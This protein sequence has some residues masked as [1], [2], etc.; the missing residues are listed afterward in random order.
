[1]RTLK[2]QV[3]ITVD[4][5][6]AG[7]NGEMDMMAGH[8]DEALIQY[9]RELTDPIDCVVL[10]RKLAEG[11]I[12]H[13]ANVAKN[14]DHPE[15]YAGVKFTETPKVVFTKTLQKSSW[16]NTVLAKGDIVDEINKLKKQQGSDIIAYGGA[17]FVSSLIRHG[18]IDDMHLFIS[19]VAIG[20]G[21]A[22]FNGLDHYQKYDLVKASSFDCGIQ[23]LHYR[24]K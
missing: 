8:W 11:F 21:M 12:P 20:K 13:W 2:L 4:G 5:F 9:V 23:I 3:Q 14:P 18:L 16:D 7:P 24:I 1:M 17:G 10:G 6:I 15:Y 19:P 22:I